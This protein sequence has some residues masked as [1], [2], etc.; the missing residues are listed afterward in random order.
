MRSLLIGGLAAALCGGAALAQQQDPPAATTQEEPGVTTQTQQQQQR[1]TR[2]GDIDVDKV[3]EVLA[4]FNC[5]GG[6]FKREPNTIEVEDVKCQTGQYD[7]KLHPDDYTV[8]AV[9]LD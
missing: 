9:T 1:T 8:W 5:Q 3:K 4:A 7:F 6:E 2:Q